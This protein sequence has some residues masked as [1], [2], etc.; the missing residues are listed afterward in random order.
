MSERP[1]IGVLHAEAFE[2]D[3]REWAERSAY[4]QSYKPARAPGRPRKFRYR[5][6]LILC[7]N[8]ARVRVDRGTLLVRN[9][10]TYYPQKAEEV[11][12][13]PG[14]A[15]LPDRIVIL[16]GSGGITF[17]A[18]AWM[19]EQQI[20]LVQLDWRGRIQ[21]VGGNAAYAAKPELVKAQRAAQRGKRQIEIARWLIQEK[22]AASIATL[23]RIIPP[24]EIKKRS[25]LA[26]KETLQDV[27][28]VRSTAT[29]STIFGIEGRAAVHY[30]RAQQGL[31]IHWKRTNRKLIPDSWHEIGPRKMGW[32]KRS[33]T[34]RHPVNAMLNYGYAILASQV[35]S[36]AIATGLDPSVGIM[37]GTS[38]NRVP[39]VYDI[40]EPLRP[41]VDARVLDFVLANTFTPADFTI[42]QH[43]GCRINPQLARTLVTTLH[44]A[45]NAAPTIS[46]FV[47][48]LSR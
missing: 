17:D 15:N 20:T 36:Q 35:R 10:F 28:A 40:M 13:F 8:G 29:L 47:R 1:P 3:D 26:L 11:R 43:G 12:F 37:H 46:K 4:W 39:L 22:I 33:Q 38:Q 9:G 21:V 19:F 24:S 44:S 31:P 2:P 34:A 45:F 6:P 41:A 42:N 5:E 7:G 23:Q 16:D 48:L 18:L 27:K 14:D 25:L 32:R 30:F